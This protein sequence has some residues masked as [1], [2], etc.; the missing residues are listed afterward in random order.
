[1]SAPYAARLPDARIIRGACRGATQSA[2]GDLVSPARS[3]RC[4]GWCA[5]A[6]RSQILVGG[7]VRRSDIGRRIDADHIVRGE[8]VAWLRTFVGDDPN[9]PIR[10]P[11]IP[12][13]F[14]M[15][16]MGLRAPEGRRSR[17]ATIV[18]SVGCPMGC[19]FCTTS[20]FFGGKGHYV[21][22]YDTGAELFEVMCDAEKRLG[23]QSFFMMDENFLLYKRRAL[24][25][26]DCM[27]ANGKPG[28]STLPSS[29]NAIRHTTARSRAGRNGSGWDS[30]R[31]ATFTSTGRPIRWADVSFSRTASVPVD[32]VGL[33]TTRRRTW[34]D[35]IAFCTTRRSTSLRTRR[36]RDASCTSRRRGGTAALDGLSGGCTQ[37]GF[38]FQHPAISR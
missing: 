6:P 29:A 4:A 32:H 5:G 18:P 23:A 7:H 38:N 19:G 24:E 9:A 37:F 3:P 13:G 11:L 25:L 30:N 15:R 36:C 35:S 1:M 21:N 2:S 20:A 16:V 28:R 12:S 34:G 14:G 31:L 8:G 17:A 10:H 26:L 27:R 33:G 22:F